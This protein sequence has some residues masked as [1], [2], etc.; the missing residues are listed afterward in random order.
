MKK[1]ISLTLL[2][3]IMVLAMSVPTFASNSV[4]VNINGEKLEVTDVKAEIVD[5]ELFVPLRAVFEKLGATVM[6]I[7]ENATI[8]VSADDYK[9]IAQIGNNK[10]F[11][12]NDNVI[13]LEKAPYIVN[14]RTL[15][16]PVVFKEIYN[17]EIEALTP[18]E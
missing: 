10:V 2:V 15:I 5:G 3:G 13:E 14:N 18:Q 17:I 16:S 1:I 11:L 12:N 9:V 8:I 7:E 6:W 4:D